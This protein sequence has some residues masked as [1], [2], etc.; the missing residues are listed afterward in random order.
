MKD[1][2][3]LDTAVL[4]TVATLGETERS[5][6]FQ[7]QKVSSPT[8]RV[9]LLTLF[10]SYG[11]TE[12]T[13]MDPERYRQA[14]KRQR[15]EGLQEGEQKAMKKLKHG[16]SEQLGFALSSDTGQ[17]DRLLTTDK[18]I[19]QNFPIWFNP[20]PEEKD[21]HKL[22]AA[23]AKA[24]VSSKENDDYH[25]FF[26]DNV[27]PLL[28]KEFRPEHTY[29]S[30]YLKPEHGGKQSPDFSLLHDKLQFACYIL[31]LIELKT[32]SKDFGKEDKL[33]VYRYG[34]L[35]LKAQPLRKDLSLALCDC[36]QLQC[37]R[38]FWSERGLV[39]QESAPVSLKTADG[40]RQ[41]LGLLAHAR[42]EF[43]T[44]MPQFEAKAPRIAIAGP[45]G[46]G[47]AGIVLQAFDQKDPSK[48]FALKR[49]KG[50]TASMAAQHESNVLRALESKG[51]SSVPKL[52]ASDSIHL[53]I[54]PVAAQF[55]DPCEMTAGDYASLLTTLKGAHAAGYAHR[56][57]RPENVLKGLL[58][59][60]AT[61]QLMGT[62]HKPAGTR[63]FASDRLL[64]AFKTPDV[65]VSVSAA[66]DLVSVVRMAHAQVKRLRIPSTSNVRELE[67]FW[68]NARNEAPWTSPAYEAAEQGQHDTVMK[69]L[70]PYLPD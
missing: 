44:P 65:E 46:E 23:F 29:Q 31:T 13:P 36:H 14:L 53:L 62:R 42:T 4:A 47:A 9:K 28:P 1:F 34:M 6:F 69:L 8:D 26:R 11:S 39:M 17:Y 22:V 68:T 63:R 21:D 57:V 40:V 5:E 10:K 67:D 2:P 70:R 25:P 50:E 66:D 24:P 59:D 43:N 45:L 64:T 33:Q 54:A 49:F 18:L 15:E 12:A 60:W 7:D 56:D 19:T 3:N 27:V 41:L 32:K 38:V 30:A 58:V 20:S 35:A 61:S 52:I 37:F 55:A 51:V 48:T 16:V